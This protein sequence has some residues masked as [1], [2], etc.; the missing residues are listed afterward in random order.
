M[1][2][3]NKIVFIFFILFNI[4]CQKDKNPIS[5]VTNKIIESDP[6]SFT[7]TTDVNSYHYETYPKLTVDRNTLK[8][9]GIFATNIKYMLYPGSSSGINYDILK[10]FIITP[11]DSF[12]IIIKNCKYGKPFIFDIDG[13]SL[14]LTE[15]DTILSS[16]TTYTIGFVFKSSRNEKGYIGF[17]EC[18]DIKANSVSSDSPGFIIGYNA[19]VENNLWINLDKIIWEY[20]I[21]GFSHLSLYLKG[22][23]NAYRIKIETYGDGIIFSPDIPLDNSGYFSCKSGI[24]FSHI[25]GIYLKNNTRIGIYGTLGL[26]KIIELENPLNK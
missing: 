14:I 25:S 22:R 21:E 18:T 16:D 19:G 7:F 8:P 10:E 20:N 9:I 2:K 26:P 4:C 5:N 24:S 6:A 12:E 3:C 13:T 23:T 17:A 11:K 1:F 15:Q